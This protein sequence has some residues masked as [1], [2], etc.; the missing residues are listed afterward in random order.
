MKWNKILFVY[1]QDTKIDLLNKLLISNI[2]TYSKVEVHIEIFQYDIGKDGIFGKGYWEKLIRD[3]S[4]DL[5]TAN[6]TYWPVTLNN[7]KKP[8]GNIT[9]VRNNS[10]H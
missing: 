1:N 9:H 6:Q 4:I 5:K 3:C 8:I 10:Y 7:N 2:C